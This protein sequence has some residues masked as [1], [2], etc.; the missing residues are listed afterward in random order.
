MTSI[1]ITGAT[2]FVGS[3]GFRLAVA[4]G[5]RVIGLARSTPSAHQSLRLLV[6]FP[7]IFGGIPDVVDRWR[8]NLDE[9]GEKK[10]VPAE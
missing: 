2:G 4:A 6:E 7:N 5:F 9:L 8:R 10:E 3:E 1:F